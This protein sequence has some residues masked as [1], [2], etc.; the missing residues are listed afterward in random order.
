MTDASCDER[1]QA[2]L[3]V[4]LLAL[5]ATPAA[6]AQEPQWRPFEEALAVAD[7]SERPI[8]VDVWAPWCSWCRKM[9]RETYPA[10]LGADARFVLTRLDRD[11]DRTTFRY[12]GRRQ[13]ARQLARRLNAHV[14]P[15]VV[16]LDAEGGYLLHVSG[17][18]AAGALAPVLDYVATGAYRHRSFEAWQRGSSEASTV[19]N[20]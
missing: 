4:L 10:L 14:V 19:R 6:Q 3:F 11:D 7:T 18:V 20:E 15:T 2:A 8:L 13:T 16:L 9:K 17:F 1:T 12:R 5:L